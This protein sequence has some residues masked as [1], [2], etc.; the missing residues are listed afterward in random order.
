MYQF[1]TN[2]NELSFELIED[3]MMRTMVVNGLRLIVID[4]IIVRGEYRCIKE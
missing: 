2:M 3:E 1:V 4:R